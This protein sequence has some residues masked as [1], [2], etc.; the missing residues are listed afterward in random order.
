[1][2]RKKLRKSTWLALALFIYISAM[3]VYFLPRNTEI[4]ETE[5][6]ITL[7]ASYVIVIVLW[8]VLRKKENF[9]EQR[10]KDLNNTNIK[11]E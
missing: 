3:A 11:N 8:I 4:T 5:K 6:Y 2:S 10:E 1:M 7:G 9:K